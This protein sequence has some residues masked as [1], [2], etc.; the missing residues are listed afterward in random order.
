MMSM[1]CPVCDLQLA[2]PIPSFCSRCAWDV[3]NDITLNT[4][5]S[6]VPEKDLSAYR[7]RL[8]LSRKNWE[9]LQNIK[10]EQ[11]GNNVNEQ[12]AKRVWPPVEKVSNQTASLLNVT[13]PTNKNGE[14]LGK[15]SN[16]GT[17][18]G[19]NFM[20]GELKPGKQTPKVKNKKQTARTNPQEKKSEQQK[21]ISF[22]ESHYSEIIEWK[23][24]DTQTA[25]LIASWMTQSSYPISSKVLSDITK[26][27]YL[28]Q[29]ANNYLNRQT[30]ELQQ[31]L[32]SY[33]VPAPVKAK[34]MPRL[35]EWI[36]K[37][38]PRLKDYNDIESLY[39]G[40]NGSFFIYRKQKNIQTI[41]PLSDI[42]AK[43]LLLKMNLINELQ[44]YFPGVIQD[45]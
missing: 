32:S 6:P 36:N 28:V 26:T 3:K 40:I 2:N 11:I 45:A 12:P 34:N 1:K 35:K 10:K 18:N 20:I 8:E 41:K 17:K 31:I 43:N 7:Q 14:S 16:T 19:H 42:E 13:Q 33:K 23:K 44:K 4:F 37:M 5:L 39:R 27:A 9:Y 21:K 25:Q 15:I 38:E 24:Y 22:E 29:T 30:E